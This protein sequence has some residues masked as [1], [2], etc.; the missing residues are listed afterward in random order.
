MLTDTDR[1]GGRLSSN[2]STVACQSC[3]SL[4]LQCCCCCTPPLRSCLHGWQGAVCMG[5]A[6]SHCLPAVRHIFCAVP[7]KLV[8]QTCVL[9][10]ILQG[11][12]CV[13]CLGFCPACLICGG[14]LV[15]DLTCLGQLGLQSSSFGCVSEMACD[16][17]V[18][19]ADPLS[20]V[21]LCSAVVVGRCRA[22]SG[23]CRQMACIRLLRYQDKSWLCSLPKRRV[24][25]VWGCKPQALGNT[26][27][28]GLFVALSRSK[29][30]K[31]FIMLLHCSRKPVAVAWRV[32][33]M[34]RMLRCQVVPFARPSRMISEAW[35]HVPHG[36]T[37]NGLVRVT[38]C[39]LF[40]Y[41]LCPF[42]L[43]ACTCLWGL[44][45]MYGC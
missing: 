44:V 3:S 13:A 28:S 27:T 33:G 41:A 45:H 6:I 36:C 15:G 4:A 11:H 17:C 39:G 22:Q 9:L 7:C 1:L 8:A 12:L 21:L 24:W 16:V 5:C 2:I 14:V 38:S 42:L 30:W 19:H 35:L 20:G 31:G 43:C 32:T 37:S 18:G 23:V 10:A 40:C 25:I 34:Q 26:D 29:V